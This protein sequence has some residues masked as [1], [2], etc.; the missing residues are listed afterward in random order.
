MNGDLNSDPSV[1]LDTCYYCSYPAERTGSWS[2]SWS[3]ARRTAQ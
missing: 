3:S 2:S 1:D